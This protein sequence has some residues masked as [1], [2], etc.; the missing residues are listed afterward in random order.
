MHFGNRQLLSTTHDDFGRL[1]SDDRGQDA[2]TLEQFDPHPVSRIEFFP[3]V[4]GFGII[5]PGIRQY[6]VNIGREQS[7]ATKGT[8]QGGARYWRSFFLSIGTGHA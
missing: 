4:A 1:L 6:S 5:H 8:L 2:R 7:D 3:F